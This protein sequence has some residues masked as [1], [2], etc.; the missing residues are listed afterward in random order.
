MS[1]FSFDETGNLASQGLG[2]ALDISKGGILLETPYPIESKLLSLMAVDLKD[3]LLEIKGRL[4]HSKK[5]STGMY[6]SGIAFFGSDEQVADFVT[7][8]VKEHYYRKNNLYIRW[9][10][11]KPQPTCDFGI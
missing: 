5:T 1:H 6:L 9:Y 2:K 8:L 7:K 10:S 4:I 11:Q 3:N